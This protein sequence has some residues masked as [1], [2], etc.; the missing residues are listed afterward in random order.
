MNRPP[1]SNPPCLL[2]GNHQRRKSVGVTVARSRKQLEAI[3]KEITFKVF[4]LLLWPPPNSPE[5]NWNYLG[6]Y[7]N[8]PKRLK[9]SVVVAAG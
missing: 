6:A 4:L 8:E 3:E 7:P 5:P 9:S 2:H 1:D